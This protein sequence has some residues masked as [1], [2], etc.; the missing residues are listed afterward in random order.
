MPLP[1]GAR[2]WSVEVPSHETWIAAFATT[3]VG[4]YLGA[5][6]LLGAPESASRWALIAVLLIGGVPLLGGLGLRPPRSIPFVSEL[7]AGGFA[8][9]LPLDAGLVTI[10]ACVPGLDFRLQESELGDAPGS[11]ALA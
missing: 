3:G 6:Y 4:G 8:G 2:I 11:E 10:G 7:E 9:E 1:I 5:R